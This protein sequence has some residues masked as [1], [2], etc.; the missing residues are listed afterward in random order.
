MPRNT[1]LPVKQSPIPLTD[2]RRT[3]QAPFPTR[4]SERFPSPWDGLQREGL[5]AT[6]ETI[7]QAP[8]FPT[9]PNLSRNVVL[10]SPVS[11]DSSLPSRGS[12]VT[13]NISGSTVNGIVQDYYMIHTNRKVTSQDIIGPNDAVEYVQV[14]VGNTVFLRASS[15][16]IR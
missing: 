2:P 14:R 13:L 16:I 10:G 7:D 15:M 1:R 9:E 5:P 12:S 6:T 3:R 8:P 11:Q 4:S